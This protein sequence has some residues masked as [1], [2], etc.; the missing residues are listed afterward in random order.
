MKP[1]STLRSF[2]LLVGSS[3]LTISYAQAQFYWDSNSTTAGFGSTAGTWGT[4]AF[5]STSSAGTAATAN[6]AITAADDVNFGTASAGYTGIV[7]ISGTQT[8]NSITI[9]SASG[10]V[11]LSGGTAFN[12][13]NVNTVITQN[14]A[15]DTTISTLIGGGTNGQG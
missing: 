12:L 14:S 9:G 11:T 10:A 1:K 2:L 15:S 8:A 7:T 5:W 6:T 13:G 3:L 4:S